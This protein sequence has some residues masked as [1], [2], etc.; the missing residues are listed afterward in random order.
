[1]KDLTKL[2]FLC[3][4]SSDVESGLEFLP[5]HKFIN[6]GFN[7]DFADR[8]CLKIRRILK[9]INYDLNLFNPSFY[10][11]EYFANLIAVN[12]LK[13]AI[14]ERNG[15][16]FRIDCINAID[17][18]ASVFS[19]V[20]SKNV[21]LVVENNHYSNEIISLNEQLA[22][23]E[24]A[25]TIALESIISS[26]LTIRDVESSNVKHLQSKLTELNKSFG[27]LLAEVSLK[28]AE[29]E[30]LSLQILQYISFIEEKNLELE[31]LRN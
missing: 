14:N 22:N 19:G 1:L 11:E 29:N 4:A 12:N 30:K 28:D 9:L 3:L 2:T 25:R 23:Y 24:E 18:T 31:E 7:S 5:K 16:L 6:L 8:K 10:H 15:T 21:A 26:R 17:A 27:F 20:A 13:T